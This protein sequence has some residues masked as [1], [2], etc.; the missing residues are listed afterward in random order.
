MEF[1]G[2][3]FELYRCFIFILTLGN[4]LGMNTSATLK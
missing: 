4:Q 1:L 3:G 2:S